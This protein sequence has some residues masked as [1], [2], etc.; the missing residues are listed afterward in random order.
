MLLFKLPLDDFGQCWAQWGA[1][2]YSDAREELAD[3]ISEETIRD[4]NTVARWNGWG[5]ELQKK[6]KNELWR[7][8]NEGYPVYNYKIEE[9]GAGKTKINCEPTCYKTNGRNTRT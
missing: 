3:F 9:I 6:A 2:G 8:N 5:K 7:A 1:N 4:A